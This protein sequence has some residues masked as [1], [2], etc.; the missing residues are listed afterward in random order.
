M[1]AEQLHRHLDETRA[2]KHIVS[3]LQVEEGAAL[4]GGGKHHRIE[5]ICQRF[6]EKQ[7]GLLLGVQIACANCGS[8]INPIRARNKK[9]GR[10]K[11]P[12]RLFVA[13]VCAQAQSVGCSKGKA[14]TAA[15]ARLAKAIRTAQ[16][17]SHTPA[18]PEPAPAPRRTDQGDMFST[19]VRR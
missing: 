2:F 5:L 3:A 13:V 4:S 15:V 1:S 8:P 19:A 14:A 12:G 18:P 10:A 17:P 6:S 7:I 9:A 16:Q 11:R